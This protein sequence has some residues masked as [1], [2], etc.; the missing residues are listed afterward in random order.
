MNTKAKRRQ[1][2]NKKVDLSNQNEMDNLNE[3]IID[4]SIPEAIIEQD[5]VITPWIRLRDNQPL[6]C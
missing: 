4:S 1:K 3:E 2:R 6:T 5:T